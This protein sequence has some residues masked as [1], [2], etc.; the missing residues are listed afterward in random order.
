MWVAVSV[1]RLVCGSMAGKVSKPAGQS[2][3]T[4]HVLAMGRIP[5]LSWEPSSVQWGPSPPEL[6]PAEDSMCS[7]YNSQIITNCRDSFF[8]IYNV[9][10]FTIAIYN[11]HVQFNC[12]LTIYNYK[13]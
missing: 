2:V 13:L 3:S 10:F 9:R 8:Y 6:A 5:G 11:L 12:K 7:Y 4:N 1:L